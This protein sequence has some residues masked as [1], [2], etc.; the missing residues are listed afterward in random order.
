MLLIPNGL[1]ISKS[2]VGRVKHKCVNVSDKNHLAI[3]CSSE[4]RLEWI[5]AQ[6]TKNWQVTFQPATLPRPI[7]TE[8]RHR[9]YHRTDTTR[10]P[11]ERGGGGAFGALAFRERE[12]AA[13]A[14]C[15][16]G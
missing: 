13:Q 1:Y 9:E 15:D 7:S 3:A 14:R 5:S 4:A 10:H 8:P 12:S 11:L 16:R 2:F 6:N